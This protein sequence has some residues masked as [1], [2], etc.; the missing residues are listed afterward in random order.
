MEFEKL[1][2]KGFSGLIMAVI[3]IVL[4]VIMGVN[5][6]MPTITGA[7]TSSWDTASVALWGIAGLVVVASIIYGIISGLGLGGR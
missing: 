3:G 2:R 6:I 1:E 5:V 4:L 7:N